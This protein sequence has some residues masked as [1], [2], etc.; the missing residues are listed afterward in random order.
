MSV[1]LLGNC[2]TAYLG[3]AEFWP[4]LPFRLFGFCPLALGLPLDMAG[5]YVLLRLCTLPIP[6]TTPNP[7]HLFKHEYKQGVGGYASNGTVDSMIP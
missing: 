6:I 5:T 2:R 1:S 7:Y 3:R 4:N